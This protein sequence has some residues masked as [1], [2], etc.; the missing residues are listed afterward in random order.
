[1]WHVAFFRGTWVLGCLLVTTLAVA[2]SP[3]ESAASVPGTAGANGTETSVASANLQLEGGSVVWLQGST[4]T[5]LGIADGVSA[6]LLAGTEL[7]V[8]RGTSGVAVY[9]VSIPTAPRLLREHATSGGFANGFTTID[10]QVWVLVTSKLAMPVGA[11]SRATGE[12][13][14]VPA[15]APEA[16]APSAAVTSITPPQ[17]KSDQAATDATN[18]GVRLVSPGVVEIATGA[19]NRTK[20]GDHFALYRTDKRAGVGNESFTGEIFVGVAEVVAV[21]DESCLAEMSRM[22]TP[23]TNDY[24]RKSRRT[25]EERSVFPT[26]VPN[27]GEYSAVLRPLLNIGTPLGVGVLADLEL[28]YWGQAY[29]AGATMQ[30][31]GIGTSA[32]GRVVSIAALVEAGYDGKAF[33]VGLG[34]GAA[35][36]NGNIDDMLGATSMDSGSSGTSTTV[37]KQDTHGAFAVSQVARLGARDGLRLQLRNVLLLHRESD[38]KQRGF[39]YGGTSGKMTIPTGRAADFFFEG[40]GGV[41]GYWFFGVGVGTWILGNGSPGSLHLS[42]SAGGAGIYSSR[43]V[44]ST[45]TY[46]DGQSWT[47]TSDDNFG[48]AGPMVSIGLTR[49]FEL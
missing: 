29:F 37:T 9:D 5:K 2:Q 42:V 6:I 34:A 1:M 17:P 27:M 45:F 40:G 8:A 46:S 39:I 13:P 4:R 18:Y 35:W 20:L 48:V 16:A 26:R 49:R 47:S 7:Y 23:R 41:M 22:A 24:A 21:R 15:V 30:P 43:R 12:S 19:A 14:A 32:D 3:S 31:L 36:V 10:G 33:S 25:E 11:A 38:S 28:T 44:T